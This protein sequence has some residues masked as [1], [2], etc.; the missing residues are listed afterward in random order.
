M[1]VPVSEENF[2]NFGCST[3][4][5]LVVLDRKGIVKL[6][7]PGKISYEELRPV[8]AGTAGE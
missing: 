7:R 8:V 4:P 2:K 1:A 3:S 5:T 6:Y